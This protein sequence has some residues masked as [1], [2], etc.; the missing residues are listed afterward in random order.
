MWMSTLAQNKFLSFGKKYNGEW[1]AHIIAHEFCMKYDFPHGKVVSILMISWLNFIKEIN[2]DRIINFGKNVFDI[3]NGTADDV[4]RE[5]TKIFCLLENPNNL[6]QMGVKLE[7]IDS[8]VE[9][10]ML[11]KKLGKYKLLSKNDV[12]KIILWS[13][14]GI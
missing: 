5:I 4:I 10:A 6:E 9:N 11:G 3:Q 2:R 7:D 12:K 1:V 14:Y 8:I 13:Y